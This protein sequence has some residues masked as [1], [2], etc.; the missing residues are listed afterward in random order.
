MA[1]ADAGAAR[2]LQAIAPEFGMVV[3]LFPPL[4]SPLIPLF[5]H[6]LFLLFLL[7]LHRRRRRRRRRLFNLC[8]RLGFHRLLFR[9]SRVCIRVSL[10]AN[11]RWGLCWFVSLRQW[12]PSAVRT[13]WKCDFLGPTIGRRGGYREKL[14]TK[15]G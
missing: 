13:A 4:L 2:W 14:A 8:L 3:H 10:I 1:G 11:A 15:F 5:L 12:R 7:L 9:R 6:S